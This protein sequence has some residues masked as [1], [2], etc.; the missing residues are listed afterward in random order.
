MDGTLYRGS[1]VFPYTRPFLARL[2][3]LGI[4][5]TFLTNNP[6]KSVTDYLAHL[7]RMGI[8]AT[9][10]QLQTTTQATIAE[11]RTRYPDARRLFLL[12]TP[13]MAS[14]F[15]AAGFEAHR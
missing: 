12:G 10:E 1:T 5:Y 2:T 15:A 13:S 7:L 4:G 3:A 14:E 8:T 9:P 11:L 6:S